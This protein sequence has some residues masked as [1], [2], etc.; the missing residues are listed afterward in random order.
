[1]RRHFLHQVSGELVKTHDRLVVENLNVAGMLAGAPM[2]AD[3][4]ALTNTLMLV[5]PARTQPS[6][7]TRFSCP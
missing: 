2:P 7:S 6:S 4:T 5:K 1:M 3:G